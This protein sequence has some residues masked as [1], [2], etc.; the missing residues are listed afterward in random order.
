MASTVEGFLEFLT[1]ELWINFIFHA[2]IPLNLLKRVHPLQ[3]QIAF[4]PK[5]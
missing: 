5:I 3:N 4:V 1:L 2:G